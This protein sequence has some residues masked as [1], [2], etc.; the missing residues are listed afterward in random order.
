VTAEVSRE[1]ILGASSGASD[2]NFNKDVGSSNHE[3]VDEIESERSSGMNEK[4]ETDPQKCEEVSAKGYDPDANLPFEFYHYYHGSS[5]D[6]GTLIEVILSYV[7][8]FLYTILLRTHDKIFH[9]MT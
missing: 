4:V 3:Y 6:M 5:N 2:V 1:T 9:L 7:D 8:Y